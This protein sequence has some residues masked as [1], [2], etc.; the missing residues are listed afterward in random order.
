MRALLELHSDFLPFV[1]SQRCARS[2]SRVP[3]G[4]SYTPPSAYLLGG[5]DQFARTGLSDLGSSS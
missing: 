5:C 3:A 4:G 1:L 2:A